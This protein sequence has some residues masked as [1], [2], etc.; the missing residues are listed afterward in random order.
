MKNVLILGAGQSAPRLISYML[1]EAS[2]NEWFVTV[3]D[4]DYELA[5]RR[6]NGH[7]N[8]TAIE[9]D[10][11]DE[12]MRGTLIE[13]T[14]IVINFLSPSFQYVIALECLKHGKHVVTASY[15]NPR[16]ADFNKDAIRKG[17]I[18]LNEMG[19][20]PGIDHM[21]AMEII[22]KIRDKDGY[23]KSFI[24]YGSA[25]PAPEVLSNP[26]RY[27]ITWNARNVVM[28]GETGAQY[29]EGGQ[30]KL[31]S[32]PQ[33]F[34]RTWNVD[35]EGVGT[36]EAYPNRD[37]L[38]YQDIFELKKADTVIRGT[39][40]YPGWS[41]TWLQIIKL[42]ITNEHLVIP[43]LKNRTYR[44]VMEM[45][46][47]LHSN[48]AGP[49]TRIAHFLDINPTGKI[50]GNLKWLGLFSGEKIGVD[51]KTPAELMAYIL[52]KKL[53][54][55]KDARDM[56]ILMHEIIG[57]YP[58]ENDRKE[59]ITATF[60]E[61][62]EPGGDTAIAKTVGL[63]AAIAAKLILKNELPITG[64][65]I[66]MHPAIYTRVLAELKEI[67]FQFHEKMENI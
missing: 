27:C 37:S 33:L 57:V 36:L 2:K 41:E 6:I 23:V 39:L 4:R 30:I 31:I 58:K 15:E 47:P 44:E 62:G 53:P 29:M 35:V 51:L 43:D 24:S 42:G 18:I 63:P 61:Y 11:N 14:D 64:C 25:I 9:F 17:I 7:P 66:P 28:A 52:N 10:V 55:P 67:G 40:R 38:I 32:H 26:L 12:N 49:E 46:I 48:G 13:N 50:M 54:L 22:Q 65:H 60:I 20:D 5:N 19:L 45:L 8:G 16:V 59:K 1:E 21:T 3:C 56:V 34:K